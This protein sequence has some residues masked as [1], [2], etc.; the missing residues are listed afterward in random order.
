MNCG[1]LDDENIKKEEDLYEVL[2]CDETSDIDQIKCEYKQRVKR[3][4]PDKA[5]PEDKAAKE[6]YEK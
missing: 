4:H 5:E 3:V 6:S 2:G 1:F